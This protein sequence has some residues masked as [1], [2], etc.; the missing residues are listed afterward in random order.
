VI[1]ICQNGGDFLAWVDYVQSSVLVVTLVFLIWQSIMLRRQIQASILQGI[2][3]R[4]LDLDRVVVEK[5]HLASLISA[6]A[7]ASKADSRLEDKAFADLVM[8]TCELLFYL[9][10]RG[11]YEENRQ[12]LPEL[13]QNEEFVKLWRD[14]PGNHTPEFNEEV[15]RLLDER[16]PKESDSAA[17]T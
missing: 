12:Y 9:E 3:E 4:F 11:I 16:P 2:H 17:S 14:C 13:L 6:S 7:S 5:P 1:L 15:R 10:K 8:D